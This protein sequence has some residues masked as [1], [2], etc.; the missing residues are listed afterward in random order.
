[1]SQSFNQGTD[2][3][4][5]NEGEGQGN[6]FGDQ[7]T[8]DNQTP[9]SEGN[10]TPTISAEDLVTLQ[11]RD[12]HAQEHISNL[13][14]EAKDLKTLMADMQGKLDQAASV[15]DLLKDKGNTTLNADEVAAK[16]AE[17]VRNSMAEESAQEKSKSN[18]DKVSTALT[19]KYGK[20][21][22]EAV[23][24]AC[25]DNDM[26][27]E[28]MIKLSEKNPKLAMKLCEVEIRVEHQ[29][30]QTT[31]NTNAVLNQ[32]GSQEPTKKV[33][34]MELRTD[35]ARVDD[36]TRRMEAKIKELK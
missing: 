29:P 33:N 10:N 4:T 6:S 16:A 13:E 34:V 8:G 17:S 7:G 24:K 3:G 2:Q 11:K 18:F 20:D 21:T 28:E 32:Y 25:T 5:G 26:T 19:E 9:G 27:W 12:T 14:T 22:D 23:K 15:E 35:R 1:M 36:F 30:A 31:I